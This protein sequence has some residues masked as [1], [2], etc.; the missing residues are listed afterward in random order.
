MILPADEPPKRD[1]DDDGYLRICFDP[2]A[3]DTALRII[4][5]LEGYGLRVLFASGESQDV[6]FGCVVEHDDSPT[7]I[8]CWILDNSKP[9]SKGPL[10]YYELDE[11]V[12]FY[13]Y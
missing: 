10:M 3:H 12:G 13:V 8:E 7:Q 5:E 9:Q 6:I 1:P 4:A 11:I 2:E